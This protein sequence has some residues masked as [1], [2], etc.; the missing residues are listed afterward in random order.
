MARRPIQYLVA[1]LW[2][3]MSIAPLLYG[4]FGLILVVTPKLPRIG[5]PTF[6]E[7]F[8]AVL[9]AAMILIVAVGLWAYLRKQTRIAWILLASAYAPIVLAWLIQLIFFSS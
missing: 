5:S 7:W 8:L 9:S 1:L 6:Y 3:V 2:L 4:A